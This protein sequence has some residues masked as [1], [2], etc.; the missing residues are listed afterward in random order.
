M[1]SLLLS[2]F[3]HAG[4]LIPLFA[5]GAFG[6]VLLMDRFL[7]LFLVLPLPQSKKFFSRIRDLVAETRTADAIAICEKN[8]RRPAANIVREGLLRAAQGESAVKNGLELALSDANQ[9]LSSRTPMLATLANVSTL[10]GLCGTVLGLIQSFSS[11]GE[12]SAQQRAAAMAVGIS[13]AMNATLLGLSIAICCM[14]GYSILM[15]RVNKLHAEMEKA[16][17]HTLDAI[18][19]QYLH[20]PDDQTG[21]IS[22]A[23]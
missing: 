13:T 23:V 20:T 22:R 8:R 16:A 7:A 17:L 5:L 12:V 18:T 3:S 10:L 14:I 15:S 19:E 2:R 9:K 1:F 4:H 11:V 6:I 21:E